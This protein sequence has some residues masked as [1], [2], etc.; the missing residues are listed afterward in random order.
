MIKTQKTINEFFKNN[1]SNNST[2]KEYETKKYFYLIWDNKYNPTLQ[3]YWT[4]ERPNKINYIEQIFSNYIKKGDYF[5]LCGYFTDYESENK[6]NLSK[7]LKYK[8]IIYLKSHL[9]KCIRKGNDS[10]S[11]STIHHLCKLNLK[12]ALKTLTVI[13]LEDTF[14]HESFSTLVWLIIASNNNFKM[15]KYI[16]EW[17]YGIVY[18]LCKIDIMDKIEPE[19]LTEKKNILELFNLY[20]ELNREDM[21]ILY[22]IHMRISYENIDHNMNNSM[23]NNMNNNINHNIKILNYHLNLWHDRFINKNILIN[24]ISIKPIMI[25]VKDL[26]LSDWDVSAIDYFSNPKL[27]EHI[28]K[29]YDDIDIEE[30]KKMILYNSSLINFRY[31]IEI[32]NLEKW[33]IIKDY[34]GKTQKYLLNS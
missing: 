10:L 14:L 15:Q 19:V 3:A 6:Y 28:S 32:Y 17:V 24:K 9:Q 1:N 8:N 11:I 16:Y 26:E 13:M 18:L 31:K 7:E 21:S 23:N 4:S 27:I 34:V 30:I 20:N 2:N 33:N 5:Y 25:Y 12:E 22:S 29:K